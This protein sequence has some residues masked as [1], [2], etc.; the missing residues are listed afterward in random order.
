VPVPSSRWARTN[1]WYCSSSAALGAYHVLASPARLELLDGLAVVLDDAGVD[2]VEGGRG[3]P[4]SSPADAVVVPRALGDDVA[5]VADGRP[6]E[7]AIRSATSSTIACTA[8]YCGSSISWTPMKLGPDDVPVDVLQRE[9]R[10][11][12]ALS[13]SWS[14]S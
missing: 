12:R 2:E 9:P 10:S 11:M 13:R 1:H 5:G 8:A 7:V 14:R 4:G 6:A 3:A